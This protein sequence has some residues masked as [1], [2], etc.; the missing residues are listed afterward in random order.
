MPDEDGPRCR[1]A[2]FGDE[3]AEVLLPE[4]EDVIEQLST[5]R[6]DEPLGEGVHVGRARCRPH[7]PDADSLEGRCEVAAELSVAIADEDLRSTIHRRVA[8]LLRAPRVGRSV[9][10]RGVNHR[11]TTKVEEEEH[12]DLAKPDVIGLDEVA[13]PDCMVAQE[14]RPAL[15][16]AGMPRGDHVLLDGSLADAVPELEEL[17]ANALG[18]P[19]R[20]LRGHLSDESGAGRGATPESA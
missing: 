14:G 2:R 10:H 12:E 13:H 5:E 4:D 18:S 19:S 1:N 16:I 8:G 9:R 15:A 6:S 7:D 3:V 17:A 20:V 11:A